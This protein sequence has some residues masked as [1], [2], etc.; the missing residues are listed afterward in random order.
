MRVSPDTI[1]VKEIRR[2]VDLTKYLEKHIFA[3][4]GVFDETHNNRDIY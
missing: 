1:V 3:F 2:K 4:D